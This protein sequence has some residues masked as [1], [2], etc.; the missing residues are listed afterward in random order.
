MET[1][2]KYRTQGSLPIGSQKPAEY[3]P[4]IPEPKQIKQDSAPANG[5]PHEVKRPP[6]PVPPKPK[7]H[8]VLPV[9]PPPAQNKTK[10]PPFD[11]CKAIYETS[12]YYIYFKMV[13]D[14]NTKK[15]EEEDI[16]EILH[17]LVVVDKDMPRTAKYRNFRSY[18]Q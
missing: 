15:P 7:D 10:M 16:R 9:A 13:T 2:L 5:R 11:P 14:N 8:Q 1:S 18:V 4:R 6:P 12:P 17:K 3:I